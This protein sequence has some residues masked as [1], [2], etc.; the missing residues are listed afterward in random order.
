MQGERW[1]E[2]VSQIS[3]WLCG[4]SRSII[5][6][7]RVFGVQAAQYYSKSRPTASLS[8]VVLVSDIGFAWGLWVHPLQLPGPPSIFAAAKPFHYVEGGSQGLY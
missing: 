5:A 2:L 8:K 4:I 1:N 3:N 7:L 6:E